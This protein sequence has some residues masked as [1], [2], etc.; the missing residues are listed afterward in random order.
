MKQDPKRKVVTSYDVARK[1]GVSRS[2]VSRAFTDGAKISTESRAKVHAAAKELGYRVNYLARSLQKNHSNLVGLVASAL[3]TP[4]RSQQV[5][6]TAKEFLRHGYRPIL[7]VAETADEIELFSEELLNYNV[8]GIVI[9]SAAPPQAIILECQRLSVPMV[10]INRDNTK[11][12]DIV[13]VEFSQAGHLARDMLSRRTP[14][15]LAVLQPKEASH[16]VAGRSNA[17]ADACEVNGTALRKFHSNA[18][19]YRDGYEAAGLIGI[20]LD[21]IDG[22]FCATDLLALGVMD[23]LRQ[24]WGAK[25][26]ETLEIVGFDDIEQ[27]S[28]RSY[29]LSTIRQDPQEQALAAVELMLNKIANNDGTNSEYVQVVTPVHRSTTHQYEE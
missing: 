8:A 9:T 4:F 25:F 15:T 29:C 19:S 3:D 10:M 17:F 26:P 24:D 21:Q 20:E 7:M 22:L 14:K 12:A 16:S 5:K 11:G 1:A 2:M 18:L 23:R 27:S 28:W 13:R 6:F